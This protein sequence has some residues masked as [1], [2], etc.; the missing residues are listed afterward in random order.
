[1]PDD[2][3]PKNPDVG[4]QRPPKATQFQKGRSG[5]PSGRPKGSKNLATIIKQDGRQMVKLNGPKGP[6]SIMK[7]QAAVMQVGN[8]AAQGNLAA[9]RLYF[10]WLQFSES[11][12]QS[13]G[14]APVLHE[15]DA[16]VMKDLV[17][18]IRQTNDSQDET[19]TDG[20]S[21]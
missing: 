12:E 8:Q 21:E 14:L 6:R 9:A 18:R 2:Q 19:P 17:E 3:D 1:V 11:S 15:R 13:S 16:A 7:Q 20:G 4:Y 5:N 10:V